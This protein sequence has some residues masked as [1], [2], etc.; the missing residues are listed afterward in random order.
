MA[1]PI[2]PDLIFHLAGVADPS[3]SPDGSTLIFSKS[4]IDQE[5]MQGQSK[6]TKMNLED[7]EISP[8][9]QGPKDSMPKHSPDGE[10]VAFLRADA[11]QRRQLWLIPT[12]GGEARQLTKVPGGL[13]D[14]SWAPDSVRIAF[15]A[16]VDPDP[17]PDDHDPIKD[18]R[19][20]VVRRIRYRFDTLG[21]LGDKHRHLFVMGLQDS[22]PSQLTDGDWDDA[23]PAWSPDGKNIAFVSSRTED[24][25]FTMC[26]EL[27][28]ISSKGGKPQLR[29]NGLRS[30]AAACW[31]PDGTKLLTIGSED[32]QIASGTQGCL[33]ILNNGRAPKAIT[34]DSIKPTAGF[35]P[36]I[37][38]PQIGWTASGQIYFIGESKGETFLYSIH[39][40][41]SDLKKITGGSMLITQVSFDAEMSHAVIASASPTSVGDLHSLEIRTKKL[42]KLT[43]FNREFFATHPPAAWEKF[44]QT[45]G[46]IKIESR[47]FFP[48]DFSPKKR[49]PLILDIHGGP[50]GVFYDSFVLWNQVWATHGYL[51]LCVNPRG[52]TTYGSDFVKSVLAD[53]GGEDFKDIM[54]AVDEV[55]SRSYV[56][57][58]RLGVHGYSYGGFM[59]SWVVGHDTRFKA[60]CVGAPCID[61]PSFYGT[62]DIGV[63]F[64]EIQWGG[65]RFENY[66]GYL[67]HSPLT[68]VE[69]V[70]TPVLLLHGEADHRCNIEQ[71]EQYF[72]ALKR[73]GKEVEFVRFPG[74]SHLFLRFGHPKLRQ[75]YLQRT[76]D[77]F[78]KYLGS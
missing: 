64:G 9:T 69:N 23:S 70:K 56:D 66:E 13:S 21:W 54:G 59:T 75:E 41:G 30:V 7:G 3:L 77:W 67:K 27:Y 60:A 2:S 12:R 57:K 46:K 36:I 45:R 74:C 44:V 1:K 31:S 48:P 78:N 50:H 63:P 26:S 14:F 73:L 49:Y 35:G 76:L 51:V 39:E 24:H 33:Y 18:P 34:D 32:P 47:L 53:W 65:T 15:I 20:K 61:L 55:C 71:S 19:T 43:A 40:S 62:S 6:L 11:K 42:N 5:T 68:Y 58:K 25:E 10:S 28:V 52:S 37:P 4:E 72:L 8:F 22:E 17:L 29:S 38:A 16:D